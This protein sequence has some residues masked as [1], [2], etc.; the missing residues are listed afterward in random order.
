MGFPPKFRPGQI[1]KF[2]YR[3][4]GLETESRFKEVLILHPG[5]QGRVHAIDLGRLT[6][7]EREVLFEIMAPGAKGKKHN[8]PLV[9][10]ILNRMNPVEDIKNPVSFYAKFVKV[11]L[12]NKD[13]YRQYY[14]RKM[15]GV[16]VV[17]QSMVKGG[18]TNPKPLFHNTETK[19]P[20]KPTTPTPVTAKGKGQPAKK[21]T[22]AKAATP[23][24]AA[25]PAKKPMSR[26]DLIRQAAKKKD[27]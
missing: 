21:A 18:V 12:R 26:L 2:T 5:W 25:Q 1:V 8:I 6:P 4:I 9:S 16:V 22:T 15:S 3:D 19:A 7:A 24:K 17:K 23:S 10:D 27:R 14:P 20:T 11:F 13:A